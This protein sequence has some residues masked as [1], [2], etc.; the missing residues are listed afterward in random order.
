MNSLLSKALSICSFNSDYSLYIY[1]TP[2]NKSLIMPLNK[3]IS[4]S[5][6]L[7]IL[8]SIMALKTI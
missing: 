4:Y 8:L 1:Y 5:K 3:S 2:G 6:N 7:G